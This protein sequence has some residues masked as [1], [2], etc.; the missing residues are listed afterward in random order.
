MDP[1]NF[2][3]FRL[4]LDSSVNTLF[5]FCA[6]AD[7]QYTI[8]G[9]ISDPSDDSAIPPPIPRDRENK[10]SKGRERLKRKAL[11][12]SPSKKDNKKNRS[13]A[14]SGTCTTTSSPAIILDWITPVE[15]ESVCINPTA[16][17]DAPIYL[18]VAPGERMMRTIVEKRVEA[19]GGGGDKERFEMLGI[20]NEE[21]LEYSQGLLL[22]S[23]MEE[24]FLYI[25]EWT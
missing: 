11:T 21:L 4:K 3:T 20:P 6:E 5:I 15:Q 2:T 17:P 7:I 22:N 18:V 23:Y 25:I 16:Q 9:N 13:V 1:R 12:M 14:G 10:N 19:R 8:L 24:A